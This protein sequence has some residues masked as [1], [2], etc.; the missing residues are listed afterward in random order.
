MKD[1]LNKMKGLLE[2]QVKAEPRNAE[3]WRE[4]AQVKMMLG[5][6]DD[7]VDDLIECLRINPMNGPGLVLMGN[8]LTGYKHDDKAAEDYYVR[9][10]AADPMSASAHANYGT[11]LFK[12]GEKFKA[13]AE[14]RRS[15]EIDPKQCV[16]HYMLAQCYVAMQDW[17]SAWIVADEA[18]RQGEVGFEDAANF[19]RMQIGLLNVRTLAASRGGAEPPARQEKAMEQTLRQRT[20]DA[21]HEKSDPSVNM[22]MAMYM[23]AAMQRFDKMTPE[24]VKSAACEIA[25]LG[26][27]GIATDKDSHYTLK[28]IPDVDF[29]GYNLLA[30]YYVSWARAFPEHLAKVGLPFD[31]AYALAMQMYGPKKNGDNSTETTVGGGVN[32]S[33][34]GLAA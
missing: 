13:I 23:L 26:T 4:L 28:T 18:L 27:H 17:H 32:H 2:A 20:F 7:A 21:K 12:R 22:M 31:D 9:A 8:I 30:Y 5:D 33:I 25:T 1:R 24:E 34:Y 29:T 6:I 3:A 15:I 14:L 19:E 16:P 10:V 11:L